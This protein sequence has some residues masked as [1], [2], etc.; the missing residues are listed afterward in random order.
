[1]N[2]TKQLWCLHV[3]VQQT[4]AFINYL[5]TPQRDQSLSIDLQQPVYHQY[6]YS[7]CQYWLLSTTVQVKRQWIFRV[8]LHRRKINADSVDSECMNPH[9]LYFVDHEHLTNKT[10]PQ[11]N[12]WN[13]DL[14]VVATNVS[15]MG[16]V[17]GNS[18]G[19]GNQIISNVIRPAL[20][21]L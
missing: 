9:R 3:S 10:Q 12:S 19:F 17:N 1:M 11:R 8:S 6:C 14:S 2:I 18:Q 4:N 5:T 15:W 13:S 7:F 20:R 21:F 16:L